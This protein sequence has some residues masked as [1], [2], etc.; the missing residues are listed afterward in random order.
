MENSPDLFVHRYYMAKALDMAKEAAMQD[1]VPIGAVIVQNSQIYRGAANHREQSK[2]PHDHAEFQA[3]LDLCH[4]QDNWRLPDA[5]LYVTV[6]PC[7]MCSGLIFQARIPKVVFGCRNPKGGALIFS[8]DHRIEL[9]LNHSVKIDEGI[10]ADEA[11]Q[12]LRDF[13]R[14]KR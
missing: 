5:T 4:E 11:S 6:E 8:Q 12:L 1:E 7:L 14:K 3:I 9:G 13:F 2:M 10:F